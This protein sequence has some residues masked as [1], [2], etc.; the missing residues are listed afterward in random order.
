ME[1]NKETIELIEKE[2]NELYAPDSPYLNHFKKTVEYTLTNSSILKS[3][4]LYT[5]DEMFAFSEW[6]NENVIKDF[7][8]RIKGSGTLYNKTKLYNLYLNNKK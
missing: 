4:N 1:L 6:Y 2:A 5:Q 8:Y 3:A 7:W